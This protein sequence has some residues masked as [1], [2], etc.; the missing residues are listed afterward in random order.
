[1]SAPSPADVLA[2]SDPIASVLTDH[3]SYIRDEIGRY[4]RSIADAAK[5]TDDMLTRLGDL[6]RSEAIFV[7]E[8]DARAAAKT[9]TVQS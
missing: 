3:L 7:S 9:T 6:R 4:E 5:K 8:L 2:A 1:M